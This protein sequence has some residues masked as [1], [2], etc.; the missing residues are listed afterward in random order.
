MAPGVSTWREWGRRSGGEEGERVAVTRRGEPSGRD[1]GGTG[2]AQ[3]L[4]R[5]GGARTSGRRLKG[6]GAG[7]A[8]PG[9]EGGG[10]KMRGAARPLVDQIR[11]AD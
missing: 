1:L 6:E 4:R 7:L 2:W 8:P 11:P 5:R 10:G 9:S 3:K